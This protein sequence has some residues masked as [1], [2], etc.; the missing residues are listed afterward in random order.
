MTLREM[1]LIAKLIRWATSRIIH[2]LGDSSRVLSYRKDEIDH[3]KEDENL[4]REFF[5]AKEEV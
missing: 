1:L 4:I 3:R 2:A 5:N